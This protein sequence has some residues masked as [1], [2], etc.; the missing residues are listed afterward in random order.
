MATDPDADT[1]ELPPVAAMLTATLYSAVYHGSAGQLAR[2][3]AGLR[4]Y[5]D[6]ALVPD[7]AADDVVLIASE[8]AA[9]AVRH[10]RSKDAFFIVRAE[11]F[12]SYVWLE[13]EDLGGPWH[14]RQRD[15]RPHGLDIITALA[16]AD[17]WGT[18][19]TSDG[20]RVTW[21]RIGI[22]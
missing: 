10:S 20:E 4:G 8:L 14:P 22:R 21:A 11:T 7:E 17:N 9:N 5:L 19:L 12:P 6:G 15:G 3:R 13:C 1:V 18:E 2:L 16:G